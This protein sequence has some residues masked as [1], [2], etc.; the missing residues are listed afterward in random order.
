MKTIITYLL[1]FGGILGFAQSS[2]KLSYFILV[3]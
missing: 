1:T 3:H 2:E